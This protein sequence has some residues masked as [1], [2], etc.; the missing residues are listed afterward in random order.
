MRRRQIMLFLAG[1]TGAAAFTLGLGAWRTR[2]R[3]V[4]N[5]L[6]PLPLTSMDWRLTNH[7][8]QEVTPADWR[9]RPAMVFFGFTYCPDVCPTTLLDIADWLEAL[10]PDADRLTVALISVDPERDTPDA[11]AN[12][13][14]H[15]DPRIIGLTGSVGATA[16]AAADFR[17]SFKKEP[18]GD[19]DY[20]MNH[21]AGVFLFYANGQFAS[22]IDF[23]EDR[24]FAVPKIRRILA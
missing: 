3:S 11:L 2:N 5:P 18:S 4:H 10:G 21:T 14:S 17:V 19:G 20:T 13:I 16:R 24:R 22:I 12:Y 23:H 9:G 1:V 15:F 8:G 6:L 7:V